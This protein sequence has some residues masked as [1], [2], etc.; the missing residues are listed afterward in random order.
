MLYE[1]ARGS[2]SGPGPEGTGDDQMDGFALASCRVGR[3]ALA[4]GGATLGSLAA[5]HRAA[6]ATGGGNSSDTTLPKDQ[7]EEILQ[8]SGTVENGVLS[9]EIDRQGLSASLPGG[10]P[11]LPEFELNGTLYFQPLGN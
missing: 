11:V 1:H 10:I 3:R 4:L 9:V 6:K 2:K 5:L 8:A 7:I